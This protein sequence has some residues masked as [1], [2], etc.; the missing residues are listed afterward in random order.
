MT[1]P[2][3]PLIDDFNR[4]NEGPPPS[5]SWDN[6]VNWFGAG[7]D[8][9]TA[10]N[11][12][13]QNNSGGG[14]AFYGTIFAANQEVYYTISDL[15]NIGGNSSSY[16]LHARLD[17]LTSGTNEFYL[18]VHMQAINP[19]KI[20][21]E[22]LR[23]FP[24]SQS[25]L[26]SGSLSIGDQIGLQ[27]IGTSITVW[28]KPVAGAW[29]QVLSFTD[30]RAN[31]NGYIGVEIFDPSGKVAAIDNFSGGSLAPVSNFSANVTNGDLPLAVTFT[32]SSTNLPTSWLWNFGDGQTSTLQNPVH[33]YTLAGIY[34]VSL[35]VTNAT[36][37][38]Q[39]TIPNYITAAA[40]VLSAIYTGKDLEVSIGG[41][42]IPCGHVRSVIIDDKTSISDSTGACD[43]FMDY[44]PMR[45]DVDVSL[46]FI[47]ST[48]PTE[49]YNLFLNGGS[50]LI[51][52]PQGNHAGKPKLTNAD[53]EI[54]DLLEPIKYNEVVLV[55]VAGKASGGM[56]EGVV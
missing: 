47:D 48:D 50:P 30:S 12:C 40:V 29:T 14:G 20:K 34:T 5:A 15:Q 32:D 45:K 38:N 27:C 25:V 35:T 33:T 31:T 42:A 43:E 21:F 39:K 6:A 26:V 53:F 2:S 49:V 37:S 13:K 7:Y 8:L 4:T 24:I 56:V 54:T 19:G 36:G 22:F 3:T 10:S 41:V 28:Y 44:L 55:N 52:Y 18:Q 11:A 46:E 16:L 1:F 51:I 9:I 23:P 17:S